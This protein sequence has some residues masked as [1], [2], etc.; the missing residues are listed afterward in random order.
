MKARATSRAASSEE[1]P[2]F[3]L[4]RAAVRLADAKAVALTAPTPGAAASAAPGL[5]RAREA[6]EDAAIAY[7]VILSTHDRKRIGGYP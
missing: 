5:A 3:R 6:V 1:T 2:L 4:V 7:S